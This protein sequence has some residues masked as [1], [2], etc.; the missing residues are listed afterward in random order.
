M[1]GNKS[2]KFAFAIVSGVGY[3]SKIPGVVRFTRLSV[4]CADNITATNNSN[5]F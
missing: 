5:G 1:N 2:S 4:H 3:F